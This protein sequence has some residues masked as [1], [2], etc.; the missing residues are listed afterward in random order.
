MLHL[1]FNLRFIDKKHTTGL[2]ISW[3]ALFC[4]QILAEILLVILVPISAVTVPAQGL[5]ATGNEVAGLPF[6]VLLHP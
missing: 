4:I 2:C 1:V 3:K 5:R 6:A